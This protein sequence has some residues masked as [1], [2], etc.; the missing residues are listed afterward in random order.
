MIGRPHSFRTGERCP[1]SAKYES[2]CRHRERKLIRE[3]ALFPECRQGGHP[4][5][6]ELFEP[7]SVR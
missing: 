3:G 5:F 7:F 4:V 2:L 1:K 6:W